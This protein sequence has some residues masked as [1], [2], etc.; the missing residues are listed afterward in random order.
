MLLTSV[1]G[2]VSREDFS[3]KR[4]S[5]GVRLSLRRR[6][7]YNKARRFWA[8]VVIDTLSLYEKL[9]E[10]MD[11]AAA[12]KL[13]Q[14]LATSLVQ[15]EQSVRQATEDRLSRVE[16]ALET[17][18]RVTQEHSHEIAELRQ[19]SRENTLA[20]A[21]LSKAVQENTSAIA[22]LRQMVQENTSAIAE[23]RQT[24]SGLLEVT[25]RHSQEIAE[26][27]QMVQENT[28]A[29]AELRQTVSGLMEVTQRHSQEIAELRQMVQEN[30][31][32]IAE[33][34]QTVSGLVEVTQR[35]SQEIAELRQ[36]VQEN[37]SAIAELRQTVSGLVEVTQRHS[38][39]IAE[40]RQA[41]RELVE[42]TKKHGQVLR[43]LEL[44]QQD[45]RKQ[46]GGLAMAFGYR[47]EDD[48]YLAL[49]RL[50][51]QDHGI[52]VQGRLKRDYLV[53]RQGNHLEVN[54]LGEGVREGETIT[55]VGESKA[56]LSANEIDR[57][58]RRKVRRLQGV[59]PNLFPIIVTYMTTS[60]DVLEHA[61]Q[62]GVA[63]F[64]SYE[65]R[66]P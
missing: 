39:E 55:I 11:P 35:H 9:K 61:R 60:P 50:L 44:D 24:V 31:S 12:E 63:V 37:T 36:M 8:E 42:T 5:V 15:I 10:N 25:Q 30:T 22:E 3:F 51:K 29:I 40:L 32:A 21:E 56:Q 20:I 26:L 4:L 14:A 6:A 57:F 53:D 52:E 13:A 18:V 27:R 41:V 16:Q 17:L 7:W 47:L 23:L 48:A 1:I 45:I 54:I 34:R 49:P 43:R 46:L 28:S 64:F 62:R 19:A 65:F 2:Y 38:Q 59:Y 33:L 58:L 66:Q